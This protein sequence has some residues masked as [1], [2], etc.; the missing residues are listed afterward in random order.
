MDIWPEMGAINR[1]DDETDAEFSVRAA[2]IREIL[3]TFRH[4]YY[5]PGEGIALE[6]E[7]DRLETE[8]RRRR[9]V[10]RELETANAEPGN[11]RWT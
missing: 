11:R 6:R 4:R 7:L 5:T 9:P 10:E 1:F 2:R 8:P 3:R